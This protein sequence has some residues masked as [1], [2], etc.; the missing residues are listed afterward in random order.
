MKKEEEKEK[1]EEDSELEEQIEEEESKI[2][3]IKFTESFQPI[4]SS[5]PVLDQIEESQETNLETIALTAPGT[6]KPKEEKKEETYA[7]LVTDYDSIEETYKSSANNPD[8]VVNASAE[9]IDPF[10]IGRDF[11]KPFQS[12]ADVWSHQREL[13]GN[14]GP[15]YV[16]KVE[17][18]KEKRAKQAFEKQEIK[19]DFH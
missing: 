9:R 6:F 4:N 2:E 8:L 7:S 13:M 16:G 10:A 18:F 15:E 3:E 5:A 11:H 19:Y 17:E 14:T 1:K 12:E